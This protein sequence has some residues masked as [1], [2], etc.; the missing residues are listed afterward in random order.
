[1]REY[2]TAHGFEPTMGNTEKLNEVRGKGG[3]LGG[4]LNRAGQVHE[5]SDIGFPEYSCPTQN[6]KAAEAAAAELP[7]LQ[8]EDLRQQMLWV[9]ELITAA[10][11]QQRE[12]EPTASKEHHDPP[13]GYDA[14]GKSRR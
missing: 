4:A 13:P 3:D 14:A 6:M 10:N 9:Q 7:Y 2:N 12:T 1:M 11:R 5:H 8:G